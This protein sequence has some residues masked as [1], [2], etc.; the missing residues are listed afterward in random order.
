M[1][2][3][4]ITFAKWIIGIRDAMQRARSNHGIMQSEAEANKE[5]IER[6]CAIVRETTAKLEAEIEKLD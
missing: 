2:K 5:L 6:V 1:K 4:N 3:E